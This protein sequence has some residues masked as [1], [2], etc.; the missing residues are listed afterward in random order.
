[1]G[2]I[3]TF[4]SLTQLNLNFAQVTSLNKTFGNFSFD[5]YYYEK[6]NIIGVARLVATPAFT[7]AITLFE[8]INVT[9]GKY[10]QI[11]PREIGF[12]F[13]NKPII[14]STQL[15]LS[16]AMNM[17]LLKENTFDYEIMKSLGFIG[18]I[19]RDIPINAQISNSLGIKSQVISNKNNV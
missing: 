16:T 7:S 11:G 9:D 14:F 3:S 8:T 15:I 12:L 19:K 13:S 18:K 4:G 6:M 5:G 2:Q 10:E 17:K 1:M